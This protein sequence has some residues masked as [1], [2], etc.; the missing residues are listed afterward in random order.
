MLDAERAIVRGTKNTEVNHRFLQFII[1]NPDENLW[2]IDA[3]KTKQ[4]FKN[5][6]V[7]L[8]S[9]VDKGDGTIG[10]KVKGHVVY[11]KIHDKKLFEQMANHWN[12]MEFG[13]IPYIGAFNRYLS[14][15][16]T[17]WSPEFAL[18]T[19]PMRDLQAA[20]FS[21]T[22]REGIGMTAR[23]AKNYPRAVLAAYRG[24]AMPNIP[25][26]KAAKDPLYEE[27]KAMGGKTG[28]WNLNTLESKVKEIETLVKEMESLTIKNSWRVPVKAAKALERLITG[29]AGA[30]ENATRLAS[31]MAMRE[32][33]RSKAEA[34]RFAKNLN[35]NFN[36][37][38]TWTA[39]LGSIFLFFNPAVQGVHNMYETL[40]HGKHK[41]Q[42][43]ALIGAGMAGM[44]GLAVLNAM[45]G[46][47]DDGIP[48]WDKIPQYEKERNIII[49]LP[50]FARGIGQMIPDSKGRYLKIPMPYQWNVPMYA[51][52]LAVDVYRNSENAAH[53]IK[54]GSAAARLAVSGATSFMPITGL[55]PTIAPIYQHTANKSGFGDGPLYPE[56]PWNKHKPDSEKYS[57]AMH[58]TGWQKW[59]SFVNAATGGSQFKEGL[60]SIP[61]S[62]WRNYV[63][64]YLGGPMSFL[65][66]SYD[67]LAE[68]DITRA[69][70]LRKAYGEI[71]FRQD[72]S[73]FYEVADQAVPTYKAYMDALKADPKAA[74][75]MRESSAIMIDVGRATET[76]MSQLG[77]TYKQDKRT[78]D[79]TRMTEA[80]KRM[81]LKITEQKRSDI[82]ERYL[83][84]WREKVEKAAAQ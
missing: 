51:S 78:K 68:E 47:D 2:E 81:Q 64:A 37:R 27:Y 84:M 44:A 73:K 30:L 46:D 26:V 10:V 17:A 63:R 83:K 13:A 50:P 7:T 34:A 58:D 45:A 38:G 57:A 53:G 31:Y 54:P 22:G 14:K 6:R 9:L 36:R 32:A 43:W 56:T 72:Q 1:D 41:G 70:F 79:S 15:S 18:Y 59:A 65:S 28:F 19:N 76:Y 42:A 33:G 71:G 16:Y 60:I 23:F 52:T 20:L 40:A 74:Q 66:G 25:G 24:E 8:E 12:D 49:V 67:A 5:G 55:P 61:P 80:E 69:P 62:V 11:M 48:Y 21:I 75:A 39:G 3:Q 35:V 77:A 4:G 29:H 82:H